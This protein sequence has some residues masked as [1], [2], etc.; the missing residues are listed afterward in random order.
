MEYNKIQLNLE[1]LIQHQMLQ[2]KCYL[3]FE[4]QKFVLLVHVLERQLAVKAVD[5]KQEWINK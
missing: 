5:L 4:T 1:S 3:F 2:P